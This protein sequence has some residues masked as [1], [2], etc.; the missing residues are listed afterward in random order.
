MIFKLKQRNLIKIGKILVQTR[1]C[2]EVFYTIICHLSGGMG[3][4]EGDGNKLHNSLLICYL[5]TYG[6]LSKEIYSN[7]ICIVPKDI[8]VQ[9]AYYYSRPLEKP[10][11]FWIKR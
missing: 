2:N 8:V 9:I 3:S 5:L 4:L 1:V 7:T 6:F 11:D 10:A